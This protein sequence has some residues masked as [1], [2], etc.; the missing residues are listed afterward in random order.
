MRRPCAD[1]DGVLLFYGAGNEAWLRRKLTEVQ[2]S[3]GTGRTKPPPQLCVVQAPPRTPAK[4]RFRT[5]YC[6]V[7]AQWN[8]CDADGAAAVHGRPVGSGPR[9]GPVS[10]AAGAN[11][12]PGLRPF[13][14]DEDH[15]FF[16]R[17]TQVDELLRRL[18]FNRFLAVVGTSGC[19]K[20]SLIRSGSDPRA[21]RRPDGE[22]RLQLADR[23]HAPRRSSVRELATALAGPGVLD[24]PASPVE[25]SGR[26]AG[27]SRAPARRARPGRRRS[28]GAP[29]AG[30]QPAR[31]RRPVRGA[32]SIPADARARERARRGVAFV[33]LLLEASEQ[34]DVP[35]YVVLTM[36]SDF[37]GDC[38]EYPG[39]PEALNNSQY[40]VPRMTRD[41]LRSAIAG[42]GGRGGRRDRA[43]AGAAP[44]ERHGV[45]PGSAAGAAA[46]ADADVGSLGLGAGAAGPHRPRRL[47]RRGRAARRALAPRRGGVRDAS[48]AREQQ[49]VERM[50]RALSDI[51]T[52]PRGGRR[53]CAVS[54]I[55]AIAEARVEEVVQAVERFRKPGR[56]FLMPP[57]SVPLTPDTIVDLSHESLMR[58]W[59]P[60]DRM[61]R[62][63]ARSAEIYLR[64][65]Q[66]RA[67]PAR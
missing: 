46:R 38:M 66:A 28:S 14:A 10:S 51:V 40:L 44:A 3:P 16:G 53:P 65:S 20:S 31:R 42:P 39:L 12:F 45:R 54:E 36:R 60:P 63:G 22:G 29:A 61:G 62:G 2:K 19:G 49:L 18:R 33:K 43:A 52:D 25:T 26:R 47:R 4:E 21:P 17:E 64:L 55:A 9:A 27:R 56:S 58:R 67:L 41:E 15:L 11:P 59:T 30:R 32:V 6:P 57:A 1:C 23:H 8:G 35:V 37:I 48:P 50:F 5:H 7:V 24:M 13:E 34:S